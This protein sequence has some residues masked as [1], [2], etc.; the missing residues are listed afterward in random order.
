MKTNK[1]DL[2]SIR[3]INQDIDN[4]TID[5]V[6][7]RAKCAIDDDGFLAIATVNPEF[8]VLSARDEHF[9]ST[10]KKFDIKVPDGF[11]TVTL[12]RLFGRGKFKQ[13][14]T[15]VDLSWRLLSL[16]GKNKYKILLLG[17][18]DDNSQK[19][20]AKIRA[21]FPSIRVKCISGG[22]IDPFDIKNDLKDEI[23]AFKPDILLVGLGAPKQE[24]FIIN[25]ARNLGVNV[26]IGVGGTIDFLSGASL[27][28][29][30]WMQ[31]V[32]I[33]WLWRLI[34]EPRR[35]RRIITAVLIFPCEYI[36]SLFQQNNLDK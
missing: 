26:A 12:P 25:N 13:R 22:V 32:G 18:S 7:R 21:N 27:R 20:C 9:S 33:E 36:R 28:A 2:S 23:T 16:A 14:I 4:T 15:G 24:Y 19:A 11:G 35:W 31:S 8:L 30:K 17:S 5:D 10:L 34:V 6:I 29:P 1:K 3:V